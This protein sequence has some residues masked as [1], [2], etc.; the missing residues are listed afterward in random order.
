MCTTSWNTSASIRRAGRPTTSSLCAAP[1]RPSGP[2]RYGGGLTERFCMEACDADSLLCC[3][4]LGSWV[5]MLHYGG[6]FSAAQRFAV[7]SEV[8][9][10]PSCQRK[11]ER[12]GHTNDTKWSSWSCLSQSACS[13]WCACTHSK[14][15]EIIVFVILI[16]VKFA[17]CP[18]LLA[19]RMDSMSNSHKV[20]FKFHRF[21]HVSEL[22]SVL[23]PTS[24]WMWRLVGLLASDMQEPG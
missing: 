3:S 8:M 16:T 20:D 2:T 19:G 15:T 5:V 24:G 11:L 17:P 18:M 21:W 23:H 7:G 13:G 14:G 6:N 10:S 9:S 12:G 22:G 1:C 4:M